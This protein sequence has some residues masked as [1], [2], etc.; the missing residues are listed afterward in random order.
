MAVSSNDKYYSIEKDGIEETLPEP[1]EFKNPDATNVE[2]TPEEQQSEQKAEKNADTADIN[3]GLLIS[4]I[5]IST[6]GLG[7]TFKKRFN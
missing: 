1:T 6:L 5:A 4:L 3:L 2:Q 7:Y